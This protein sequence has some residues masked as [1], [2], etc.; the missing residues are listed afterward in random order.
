MKDILISLFIDVRVKMIDY[1]K[2]YGLC[3]IK[4]FRLFD[5]EFGTPPSYENCIITKIE[6]GF[7]YYSD[8]VRDD[9]ST[10]T[11]S[12]LYDIIVKLDD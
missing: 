7:V 4:T 1:L 3:N 11:T 9:I 6:G 10:L 2:D 5:N 8:N 12:Q